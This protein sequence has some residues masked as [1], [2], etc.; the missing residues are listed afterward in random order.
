[1][2]QQVF[3]VEHEASKKNKPL[4]LCL[5]DHEK[6]GEG[7]MYA[8]LAWK[9]G[10]DDALWFVREKDAQ[11]VGKFFKFVLPHRIEQYSVPVEEAKE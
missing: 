4:F 1:M 9:P 11:M 10:L 8:H 5:D 2:I 6:R 3:V 7:I